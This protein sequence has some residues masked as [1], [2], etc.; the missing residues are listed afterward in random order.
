MC[1][2]YSE[3]LLTQ[4]QTMATNKNQTLIDAIVELCETNDYDIGD[5]VH[6]LDEQIKEMLRAEALEYGMLRKSCIPSKFRACI[7]EFDEE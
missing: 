7:L 1:E 6:T 2:N 5:F 4:I 3:S